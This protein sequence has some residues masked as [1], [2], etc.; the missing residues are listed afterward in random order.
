V[1]D[2]GTPHLS[3]AESITVAVREVNLAPVLGAIGNQTVDEQT[4]LTFTAH[5]TDA[6]LPANELVFSL[7]G[8]PDGASINASTGVF[9]WTPTEAQGPNSYSF[10]VRATDSG[11]PT[12]FDEEAVSVT[13][14]EVNV[15]PVLGAIGNQA[16]NEQTT[17]TFTAT[18]T[19]ADLPANALV[20]S[21]LDA[22][23]GAAINATTGVFTWTPTEAQGP[24]S[25]TFAVVVTDSGT[26]H[27]S[28][29]ESITVTVNEVNLAPAL[30]PIGNKGV[31]EGELL[32]FTISATDAD[33]PAN[34]L[35]F[36]ATGLPAGAT[37][38]AATR[39]FSWMP[40]EPQGPAAYT[41]NFRVA[42]NGSPA[43]F[44]DESI[45]I[46]VSEDAN[47]DAGPQANDGHTDTFR[48]VKSD[49]NLQ[50]Y[51]NDAL[52]FVRS[53]A[54]L[55]D[56]VSIT[57]SGDNDTLIV[58]LSGGDPIPSS[59]IAYDGRGPGD[60]DTLTLT[61]GT[62]GS[63]VYTP[64]DAHSGTVS[65]DGKLISY[66]GLEPIVDNLVVASREFVFGSGNDTINVAVGASRTTVVSPSSESVDFVN[67]TGTVTIHG[68]DGNDTIV[69]TGN[70]A[71]ELLIDGGGGNNTITSSF[72]I[73][74]LV[75]G[76]NGPDDID[77]GQ[78]AGVLTIDVNGAVSTLSGAGRLIVNALGGPDTVTLHDL[79]I[80]AT[81]D[82]GSGD[83]F[84]DASGV[85]AVGVVLHGGAGDDTL[86]AG[87]GVDVLDGGEG[88]DTAVLKGITPI[89]YW[90]LNE[91]SGSAVADSAGAPQNGVFYGPHPDLD[92]QG[93]PASVAP[94]G[95]AT[96]ADFNDS[97][98]EYIAV[99]HD[100]AFEV[101]QGTIQMWFRTRDANDNQALFA[102]DRDGRNNGLRISLDDRDLRVELEDGASVRAIDTKGTSFNNLVKS[103]T[104]YQLTFTFGSGGMKLY[105]DGVLVGA[106]AYNGGLI[107]NR[108]AIVIGGS[109]E[110]NRDTSGNLSK[111]K[112][113]EPFD[114][115]IDEVAFYGQ[116][117]SAQQIAQTKQRGALG[118]IAP[119]DQDDALIGIEHI[120]IAHG[121][122][123]F[124]AS[125]S[126]AASDNVRIG[127]PLAGWPDLA[128]FIASLKHHGL[129]ELIGD[130]R[131]HGLKLFGHTSGKPALFAVDGVTLRE[132]GSVRHSGHHGSSHEHGLAGWTRDG[133]EHAGDAPHAK[134]KSEGQHRAEAKS[135]DWNDSFHGLGA[136]MASTQL[137]GKRGAQQP[138]LA[139]FDQQQKADK[140]PS[141]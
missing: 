133:G 37:F 42:D 86:I 128:Q 52:V 24:G 115:V 106:N 51:L 96:R 59:G 107:G 136:G 67:P 23:V 15:A 2:S 73:G 45:T 122:P 55:V 8:A 141:R 17:L 117:L 78:A 57:G 34:Q 29:A 92:D 82:A 134:D 94:F 20:F 31:S 47:L 135:I 66:A 109:N 72:P 54:S 30:A 138:N 71:Y 97:S 127:E 58:D 139:A 9:T 77:V 69:V 56:G 49:A 32:T 60:H 5:A 84:V 89:A 125:A 65:V 46:T 105:L 108:E 93:P 75:T 63:L 102:K 129:R 85:S 120:E 36:S 33:L 95:A 43:L 41:V 7:L 91:T 38:D 44:D 26:P 111:L 103:N 40:S 83:D 80:P 4:A 112:I 27:L 121:T 35:A 25:F 99:A 39:T 13:V 100:A 137:G 64:A 14:N 10:A 81:V 104:W 70:P 21:L 87:A 3:D 130:L 126:T 22:P 132:D 118:V 16:V 140:K 19:D 119:Q 11:S 6:D 50:G 90:N 68:G 53:I 79:T 61:G 1:T 62:V 110:T 28:D 18:A 123:A 131:E 124:T 12:L 88:N 114:G 74:A 101:A 48:L 98:S 113:T 116:A 76:T